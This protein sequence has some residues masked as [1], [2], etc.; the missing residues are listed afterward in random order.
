MSTLTIKKATRQGVKPLIGLYSES[1]CG[2]T[3]SALLLARGFVGPSGKIVMVDSESGRGSLYADVLPGGYEVLQL[4]PPFSPSRYIQAMEAV[5]RSGATIGVIDSASHE[6]E[7]VG[8]VLDMA[9]EN[10]ER[11]KKPG[12]HNWKQ[13][14]FEHAKF[15]LRLL[16]SPLPWIVCLRA[17]YKTRQLKNNGKTEIVKDEVT[18]PIQAEDFIF[19]MTAHAEIL[20]DHSIRLTKCSHPALRACF[21]TQGPITVQ[22][23]ELVAKWCAAP[24]ASKPAD[25]PKDRRTEL[26][27]ALRAETQSVHRWTRK[28]K[29]WPTAKQI[30][31]QWLWDEAVMMDT[32][33][34]DDLTEQEL[35]G[36]IAKAKA[37]LS[38]Q[39]PALV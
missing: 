5:E 2:K 33:A 30:L 6:W 10:E 28:P 8:G 31:A 16:Q 3:Y 7:G 37:K 26:L 39:Q 36:V 17:K 38:N 19:E 23:G 34:I 22:H 29:D 35:E 24:T 13:P 32:Q 1:G 4:D 18:S 25:K 11:S 20:Q 27:G 12:L 14:K 15:M 9:S 21:P